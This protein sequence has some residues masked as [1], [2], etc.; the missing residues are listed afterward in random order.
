MLLSTFTS[1][2]FPSHIPRNQIDLSVLPSHNSALIA[3]YV[4]STASPVSHDFPVTQDS[5]NN[6]HGLNEV[7]QYISDRPIHYR[8]LWPYQ[9]LQFRLFPGAASEWFTSFQDIHSQSAG[10]W[11][12]F[13]PLPSELLTRQKCDPELSH[14]QRQTGQFD[15]GTEQVEETHGRL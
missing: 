6:S 4:L 13:S 12:D 15:G 3:I 7:I 5:R 8:R 1:P 10:Q 2:S 11:A 14:S 9:K